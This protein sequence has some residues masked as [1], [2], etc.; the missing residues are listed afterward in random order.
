[1]TDPLFDIGGRQ[2]LA[3]GAASGIGKAL[4]RALAQRGARVLVADLDA[5]AAREV[6]EGLPGPGHDSCALDVRD[7]GS[8]KAA[9]ARALDG[10]GRLDVLLNSVG[11]FRTAPALELSGDD[12]AD[13]LATNVTGAFLLSRHAGKAMVAQGG[14]RIVHIASVSSRVTNPEYAAYAASKAALSHLT[15]VLA[16]EWAAHGVTVNAIGPAVIVTPLVE[17]F[18][19]RTGKYDFQMSRIPMRRFATAEDLLGTVLLLASPAGAFITGQTI[20]VDGGRTLV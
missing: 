17:D 20:Y 12:F 6:A 3:A 2:V 7:E 1:M 15:R 4:A 8:C 11:I 13:T 10:G 14:G 19:K 9:A 18:L 5:A 16:L